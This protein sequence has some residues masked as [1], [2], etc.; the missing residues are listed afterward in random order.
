MITNSRYEISIDWTQSSGIGKRLKVRET[1]LPKLTCIYTQTHR[2][3]H[4]HIIFFL[5]HDTWC[6]IF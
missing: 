1:V 5:P 4:A 6:D 2:H 3:T